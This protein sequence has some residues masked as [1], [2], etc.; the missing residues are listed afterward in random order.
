MA[1]SSKEHLSKP[2]PS[3]QWGSKIGVILA[4]AGSA[5]GLGNFL[6]FPGQA[7]AHGGGAFMIPYIISFIILGLPICWAEWIMG[8]EAGVKGKFHSCPGIFYFLTKSKLCAYFGALGLLVPIGVYTYY[9]VIESWCLAYAWSYLT[10]DINLGSDPSLYAVNSKA[11]FANIAGHESDGFLMSDGIHESIMWWAL[12]F[13]V[14]F[15]LIFIGLTKGIERFCMIAMPFMALCAIIVLIRVLTL[16][17]PNPEIP[18]QNIM[19]GLGYMWNPRPKDG[20]GPWYEALLDIETWIAAAGQVFF[21]L[22]V[23]FGVIINYASY[24]KKN[25][26]V[27]LAG[28]TAS[29]TNQFFEV[30]LGGLITILVVFIFLGV[31]GTIGGTFGLGFNTLPV[32]FE[33]MPAGR[34]FGF[35]WFFMLFLAAIT[36]SLSMLQP[37]IAFF[38][39]AFHISRKFSAILLSGF[40]AFGSLFILYFSK[41]SVALDT[42]DFWVGTVG[43]YVLA[44]IQVLIFS[45]I[46]GAARGLS[47]ANQSAKLALPTLFIPMIKY[48]TPLYLLSV[49]AIW[50]YSNLPE[51][52]TELSKGGVPLYS[53]LFVGS[54][55]LTFILF[56]SIA[57]PK[58]ERQMEKSK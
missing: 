45:W 21:T 52:M 40:S 32:V 51:R 18:E 42:V 17:T 11:F 57:L 26:D 43:I 29:A 37:V 20:T 48:I 30:C 53:I 55:L 44:I 22:S 3:E 5:V 9:I 28:A 13:S 27:V 38:S 47:A 49:F 7:V 46:F 10:N 2:Q 24:L 58:W 23:G 56:I 4:V 36:S 14:N 15:I 54:I 19:N 39:E 12:V 25:D 1:K 34:F 33:Y 6:R 35:L 41:D 31:A 16:G 50:C 8:K